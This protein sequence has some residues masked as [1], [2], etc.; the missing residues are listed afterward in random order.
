MK[1]LIAL[2]AISLWLYRIDSS[3]TIEQRFKIV[4]PDGKSEERIFKYKKTEATTSDEV[5]KALIEKLS[6]DN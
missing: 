5:R 6:I 3:E 2:A 1:L 4:H